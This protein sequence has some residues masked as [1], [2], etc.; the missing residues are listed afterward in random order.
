MTQK[1]LHVVEETGVMSIWTMTGLRLDHGRCEVVTNQGRTRPVTQ[2]GERL[3]IEHRLEIRQL[4]GNAVEFWQTLRNTHEST[5][6]ISAITMFDGLLMLEGGGW[7][8]MHSNLFKD[9]RYFGGYSM[10]TGGLFA[11]LPETEGEFGLSEDTP[12][13]GIFF[14]HPERGTVLMAALSQERCKP[15]WRLKRQGRG[16][17]LVASDVFT[18]IPAIPLNPGGEFS[19]EQ[20]VVLFTTEGVADAIDK[21]YRLLE[22]RFNFPGRDSVL[23][24]EVVWGSWNLN[25]RPHGHGDITHDYIAANAR[26][27]SKIVRSPCWIMIDDGY[28]Y[29]N[30]A[31]AKGKCFAT[32][33][34]DIFH[35]DAPSPHD[36]LRFPKGMKAMADTIRKAGPKPAIWCTPMIRLED[37]LGKE[38]PEWTLR[39]PEGRKFNGPTTWLDYSVPEA[40]EFTRE[41]WHTIFNEWGYQGLKLDFWTYAFEIPGL[42]YRHQ[43]KTAI[44]LRNL[45]WQDVREFMPPGGFL[46]TCCTTNAGN[47]FLGLHADSSRMGLDVG[48]ATWDAMWNAAVWLTVSSLFYRGDAL[49]GDPDSLGWS[50]HFSAAENRLWATVALLSGGMCEM[51]GDMT[52]L[53]AP[54]RQ[55]IDT[56]IRFFKPNRRCLNSVLEPGV[57]SLPASHWIL[58]RDDG[59][60]E[61]FMNW[62]NYPR[63][64]NLSRPMQE[65]WSGKRISGRQLIP[66]HGVL[67]LSR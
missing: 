43:D 42:R 20:W 50:P 33:G 58:E 35:R 64:I 27:F 1:T 11:P 18:G 39:L 15:C 47:P 52:C 24:E 6:Q 8:V 21:Y 45:F 9:E 48:S 19:T 10:Y 16:S 63:K 51:G 41:A 30:T 12:F 4:S 32:R 62:Q 2:G 36:P 55:F 67:L 59:V 37:T 31:N 65:I 54:A 66:P 23:R 14:T 53:D 49:L 7:T 13:P 61:A 40:R 60:Y 34:I 17:R 26:A 3:G 56:A 38:H 22:K 57:N 25:I 44:E 5:L 29:G 46:L 28:Q